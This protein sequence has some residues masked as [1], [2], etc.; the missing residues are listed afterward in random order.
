MPTMTAI[1]AVAMN[2]S[3]VLPASRAALLTLRRLATLT[4]TAVNTSGATASL[5]SWTKMFPTS[6]RVSASQSRVQ[7]RA[8]KPRAAPTTKPSSSCREKESRFMTKGSE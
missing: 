7:I 1:R 2:Q 4:T 5:R 3:S 8:A 6:V